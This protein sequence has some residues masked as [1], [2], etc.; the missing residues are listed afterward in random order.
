MYTYLWYDYETFGVDPKRDRIAQFA[1]VRTDREFNVLE[2]YE[3]FC[4]LNDDY[5]PNPEACLITGITPQDANE[6]GISEEELSKNIYEIFTVPN[7]ISVGYNSFKFDDEITRHLFYRTFRSP[8]KREWADGCSRWDFLRAVMGFYLK[9]PESISFPKDENGKPSF[10]LEL[11]TQANGIS[12]I[13][14]HDAL[15][16]VY[17]T[18]AMAKLLFAKDKELY[19]YILSLRQKNEVSKILNRGK[20]FLHGDFL[21]GSERNYHT[22]LYKLDYSFNKDEHI[23]IDLNSDLDLLYVEDALEL[24]R[25]NF[26]KKD[27][28]TATGKSRP[29]IKTLKTNSIPLLFPYTD[30]SDLNKQIGKAKYIET[31]LSKKLELFCKIEK[32]KSNLDI[33]IDPYNNFF[34]FEDEANFFKMRENLKAYKFENENFNELLKKYKAKNFYEILTENEK[35]NWKMNCYKLLNGFEKRSGYL[36]FDSFKENIKILKLENTNDKKKIEILEKVETYV[37]DLEKSTNTINY[38]TEKQ[39]LF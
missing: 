2:K 16:D 4:K 9:N 15:S 29:G 22:I 5:I 31:K 32:T 23:F 7:T 25:L 10:R 11:L 28:L 38:K 30:F 20:L 34:T 14:A 33:E 39:K 21:Y 19:E 27:D 13:S 1:G 26:L 6:K 3:Y 24:K 37:L 18:I 17:A 8:Y 36:T 35:K 12:H